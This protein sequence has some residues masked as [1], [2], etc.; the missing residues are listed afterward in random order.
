MDRLPN[1]EIIANFGVGYDAIDIDAA[2]ERGIRV[3]N[4][5]D[6]LSDDVADLALALMLD[7]SR[8]LTF[9]DRYVREGKWEEGNFPLQRKVSGRKVGILGLGRIGQAIASRASAFNMKVAYHGRHEKSDVPY[10]YHSS[11]VDLAKTCDFLVIACPGGPSTRHLVNREVLDALGPEG[12]LVN[13]A[14]GSVVVEPELVKALAEGRLGSAGL[15]VFEDEPRVPEELKGMENVV[16]Q[17]HVGS[18]TFETR[19]DMAELV[20]TNLTAHFGGKELPTPVA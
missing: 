3:T 15:D 16:L 19:K 18:A 7:V 4:T 12:C 13:I 20:L 9:G 14:R 10:E 2:K 17:P 11:L 8:R 6:V 5:P 1:L